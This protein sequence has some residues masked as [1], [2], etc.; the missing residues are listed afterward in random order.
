MKVTYRQVGREI[1]VDVYDV[2]FYYENGIMGYERHTD[3]TMGDIMW[4]CTELKKIPFVKL[5]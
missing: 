4:M 5:E 3:D 2:V 1:G